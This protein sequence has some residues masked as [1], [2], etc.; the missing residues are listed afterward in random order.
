MK[1]YPVREYLHRRKASRCSR[2]K[3]LLAAHP[4]PIWPHRL[5]LSKFAAEPLMAA[6]S[7]LW[8]DW[9]RLCCGA[10]KVLWSYWQVDRRV[11]VSSHRMA[12]SAEAHWVISF[13]DSTMP[14][15]AMP[16][17]WE[18]RRVTEYVYD[19]SDVERD[20]L[21]AEFL[22]TKCS[23]DKRFVC[24]ELAGNDPFANIA[25]QVEREVFQQSF[26]NDPVMLTREYAPYEEHSLF[27]LAV[28]THAKAPA[29]V[30]R[31]IRN[32]SSGLKTLVD[33]EDSTKSPTTVPT[34]DVMRL[35]GID[36]LDRCWDGASATVPRR[37]RRSLAA[38]HLQT[39]SAWYAAAIRE[40]IEHF[41]SILDAP[42]YKIVR[43][44]F[45]L[46]VVPLAGTSPFTYMGGLNHQAVYAHLSTTL[47]DATSGNRK[48]GQKVRDCFAERTFPGLVLQPE[49]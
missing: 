28:D 17:G 13:D 5:P 36:D 12:W 2:T 27:F 24:F 37:Y 38:I 9:P 32:S 33:L 39:L 45:A 7:S 26:G 40:N 23:S 1:P 16:D 10:V 29:G 8:P 15:D 19:M 22:S 20:A 3:T 4:R 41:V 14:V 44:I 49:R 43:G 42:I 35:H 25:R 30:L 47:S 34:A 46:P 48:L 21:T 6:K 31:M 11:C 18:H